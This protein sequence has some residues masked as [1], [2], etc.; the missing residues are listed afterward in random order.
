M[1][2]FQSRKR[3]VRRQNVISN[4]FLIFPT[5]IVYTLPVYTLT[6]VR[7]SRNSKNIAMII[8][9]QRTHA[10]FNNIEIGFVKKLFANI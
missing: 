2:D 3:S 8:Q 10:K 5:I 6:V 9:E 4:V 7:K 1:S